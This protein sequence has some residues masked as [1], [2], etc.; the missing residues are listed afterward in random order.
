MIVKKP[1]FLNDKEWYYYDYKEYKYKLTDKAPAK[2]IASY[3]KF[4]KELN[5]G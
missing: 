1:Y 5:K 4:Y 2:A 3:N